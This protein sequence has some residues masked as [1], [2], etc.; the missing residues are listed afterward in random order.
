MADTRNK[1]NQGENS[2]VAISY[3]LAIEPAPSPHQL[4]GAEITTLRAFFDL[5][6]RWDES[7]PKTKSQK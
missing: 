2:A 6:A 3:E 4:S 7:L 1:A 5:L